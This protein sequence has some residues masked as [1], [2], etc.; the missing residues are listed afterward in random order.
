MSQTSYSLDQPEAFAGMKGD[1]GFDRVE[2]YSAEGGI[3]FGI[4]LAPGTN[5]EDQVKV[6]V[7]GNNIKGIS[8]HQHVPKELGTGTAEYKDTE[9]V[10]VMRQGLVWMRTATTNSLAIGGPVYANIDAAGE[11]GFAIDVAGT[12]NILIP[13]A[14]VRKLSVDPDGI[15]IALVEVNIP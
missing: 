6:P 8:L 7:T 4:A 15:E 5:I 11:E 13:T 9:T 12:N 14:Q 2:S 1:A 10:S 3:R